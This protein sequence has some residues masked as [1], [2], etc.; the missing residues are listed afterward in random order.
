MRRWPE[1]ECSVVFKPQVLIFCLHLFLVDMFTAPVDRSRFLGPASSARPSA[2]RAL[3][4]FLRFHGGTVETIA[5]R[6]LYTDKKWLKGVV[7]NL[8]DFCDGHNSSSLRKNM[9]HVDALV[10]V[11]N[12]TDVIAPPY[13]CSLY[14]CFKFP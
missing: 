7:G 10:Y 12:I 8:R 14:G 2:D 13:L 3:V 4:N 9:Q 1:N 11:S 6:Q 5:L